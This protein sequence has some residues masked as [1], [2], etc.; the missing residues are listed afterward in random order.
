MQT[1]AMRAVYLRRFLT[2]LLEMPILSG[3]PLRGIRG[4]IH[5][6]TIGRGAVSRTQLDRE[7]VFFCASMSS[8]PGFPSA[9]GGWST[10]PVILTT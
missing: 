7:A 2:V 6:K 10:H 1:P 4:A 8:E 5:D 9:G 3:I